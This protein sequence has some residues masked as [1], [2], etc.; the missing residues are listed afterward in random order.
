MFRAQRA[1]RLIG[2][3]GVILAALAFQGC[4][5]YYN[6]YFNAEKAHGQALRL[7]HDRLD[8]NPEDTVVVSPEEKAKLDR[9]ELEGA[10]ALA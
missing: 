2:I 10:R 7:R 9:K 5:V 1:V 3:G 6:T 8:R 4:S